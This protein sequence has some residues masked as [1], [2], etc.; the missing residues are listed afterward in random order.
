MRAWLLLATL[1]A[2]LPT[3]WGLTG[4]VVDEASG[5][6]L[7][8]AV[9][10]RGGE[11]AGTDGDGRYT[12]APG[13]GPVTVRAI[14]YRR[15][16]IVPDGDAAP[17]L[18]LTP[19]RPKAL[20]LSAWGIGDR[21]L[22]QAALGLIDG[23]EL[24]ALVIDVKGDR[25]LVP[26][27]SRVALAEAVGARRY[28]TVRDMPAL[29]AELHKRGVYL[30]ARIVV[31]KD[32]PLATAHPEWA[33]KTAR[34]V[35]FRDREGL[36]WVDASRPEV[37]AYNL[38]IAEEAAAMGFDEIQ[39]DYLRFPDATGLVFA[40]PNTEERRVASISGF[41]AAA[42]KRLAPHNVFIAADIFGYVSWNQ[43]DTF[44]GQR[45]ESLAREVDYLCLMLYPSGFH[46]GIPGYTNPVQH[47][48][49]IVQLTLK[50]AAHRSG[51]SPLRFRPWLQAFRDYAFDHR[52][53]G[54][55]EIRQQ[56]DA[57]EGFGSDGWM[58]WNPRNV[59]SGE[60]L[61]QE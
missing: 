23:S 26:Y 14:G 57:A 8:G 42:R 24:N 40:V 30:I 55:P 45:I 53:F 17:P 52:P 51:L 2:W 12:L 32:D 19:I 33:V 36:A 20:Y 9:V 6:P 25:G 44:I 47:P 18:R 56:I 31:F 10:T 13:S 41:L 48:F 54:G 58:L 5:R 37:W 46:L 4:R 35:L 21:G 60:G 28:T 38:D 22:R 11:I 50:H 15:G 7:A 29:L 59:Y 49:E 27:P 61:R 43:N 34:G 16:R 1:L 3:A 39:F